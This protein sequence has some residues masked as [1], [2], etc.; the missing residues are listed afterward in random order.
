M[1]GVADAKRARVPATPELRTRIDRQRRLW[2]GARALHQGISVCAATR[3]GRCPS[4]RRRRIFTVNSPGALNESVGVLETHAGVRMRC[5]GS[6][7][8]PRPAALALAPLVDLRLATQNVAHGGIFVC[9]AS[10][11]HAAAASRPTCTAGGA[12]R[13]DANFDAPGMP[14][15][16]DKNYGIVARTT[17]YAC[18][19]SFS[20][21]H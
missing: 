17:T 4:A 10:Y 9:A 14:D 13:W 11:A 6:R 20:L 1:M 3:C 16:E 2:R 18:S 19:V 21:Q 8:A 5:A 12:I 15:F 7:S